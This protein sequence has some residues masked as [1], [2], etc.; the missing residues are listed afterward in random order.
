MQANINMITAVA[1]AAYIKVNQGHSKKG[2]TKRSMTKAQVANN[3]TIPT[4]N[5]MIKMCNPVRLSLGSFLGVSPTKSLSVIP[6][7]CDNFTSM[8]T[9][10]TPPADSHLEI[11][12]SE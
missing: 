11:D 9:S 2:A 6:Y 12:L 5:A 4:D 1:G 3:H 8:Y 7:N 10:G